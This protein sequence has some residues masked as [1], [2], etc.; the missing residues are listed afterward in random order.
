MYKKTSWKTTIGILTTVMIVASLLLCSVA[1]AKN[2]NS[3]ILINI[4]TADAAELASLPGIGISKAKAIVA[5][6]LEHGP[7]S[8]VD[9][10][11]NVNGIGSNLL[12][13]LREYIIAQ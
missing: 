1:S 4:N 5:Y 3:D 6:R 10:L 8:T 2:S 12:E 9:D 7:F 13:K 11:S